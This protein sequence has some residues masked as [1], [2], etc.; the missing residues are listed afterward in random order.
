MNDLEQLIVTRIRQHGPLTVEQFMHYVLQHPTLGYYRRR[1]AIGKEGD[2]ITAPEIS[3]M[4]G[5][6]VGLC[7]ADL[8]V[9]AGQ[10][11]PCALLELGPGRGTLMADMMRATRMVNGFHPA[12][13]LS[14]LESNE[15][16]RKQQRETLG[17]YQPR[18]IDSA[19]DL[20]AMP[21]LIIANEFFDALPIRQF[22][23]DAEG[24]QEYV[25]VEDREALAFALQRRA[26]VLAPLEN[27]PIG[28]FREIC[29]SA[30]QLMAAYGAHISRHGGVM[31]VFDYGYAAAPNA[32]TL[33]AHAKHRLASPLEQPGEIDVTAQVDFS[34]LAAVADAAGLVVEPLATQGAFLRRLGIAAR[35]AQLQKQA[36]MERLVADDQMGALF[37]VLVVR[38]PDWPRTERSDGGISDQ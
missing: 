10:P 18:W 3:Q 23:R 20:P 5:E 8:W 9:R 33:H 15:I 12:V 2:F 7:L 38:H 26:A 17:T 21:A 13:Q 32:S 14:L 11:G 22:M 1:A 19:Q 30:Q 4:F 35:A 29:P 6:L 27:I 24:W 34:A 37:K 16:L 25:V 31:L 28:S 36:D